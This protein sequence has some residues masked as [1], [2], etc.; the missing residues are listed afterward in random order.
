MATKKY[1]KVTHWLEPKHNRWEKLR[2]LE[3]KKAG[4]TTN[5][6]ER[7]RK[8]FDRQMKRYPQG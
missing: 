2:I 7:L 8:Y 6:S 4:K 5:R 1:I 3:L